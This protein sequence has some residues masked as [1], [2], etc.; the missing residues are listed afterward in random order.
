MAKARRMPFFEVVSGPRKER[1]APMVPLGNLGGS[2]RERVPPST[3]TP[4]ARDI[5]VERK[6]AP[7]G[8][9]STEVRPTADAP[10]DER[11]RVITVSMNTLMM[12][13]AGIIV[14]AVGAYV[15]GVR[16]GQSVES[17]K[18]PAGSTITAENTSPAPPIIDPTS[19]LGSI[20]QPTG[21]DGGPGAPPV[22]TPAADAADAGVYT[23]DPR[24]PG[25]NYLELAVLSYRDAVEA[26]GYLGKNGVKAAA[27]PVSVTR[28]AKGVDIERVRAKNDF[29]VLFVLE[30]LASSEYKSEAGSKKRLDLESR[31][32]AIGSRWQKEER[33]AS[34]FADTL[35]RKQPGA[36]SGG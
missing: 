24:T 17:K 36:T 15:I 7:R 23:T 9:T 13:C 1:P 31:V 5:V 2:L 26:I 12:I 27:V 11:Q 8:L 18:L 16:Y 30:G 10:A 6:P 33:G 35:W 19:P 34:N 20:L 4:P 28:G 29:C 25:V 21:A 3:L 14:A 22:L 32:K